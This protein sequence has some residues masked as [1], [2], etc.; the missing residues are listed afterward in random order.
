MKGG[1]S[2][3]KVSLFCYVPLESLR[4]NGLKLS[5]GRFRLDTERVVKH[6]R[7][8]PRKMVESPFL[9]EFKRHLDVSLRDMV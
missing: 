6:W 8:F 3:G 4:R 9:E 5:Q 1:H 2:E 7:K